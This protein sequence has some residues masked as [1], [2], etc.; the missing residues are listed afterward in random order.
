MKKVQWRDGNHMIFESGHRAFDRQTNIITTGNVIADTQYSSYI[1][2]FTETECNGFTN[3]PGH[4]QD[5]DLDGFPSLPRWIR[6]K[7]EGITYD[8]AAILY[9]FRHYNGQDKQVDGYVL[10]STE[11]AG[12]KLLAKWATGPTYKSVLALDEAIKYIT[13]KE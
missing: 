12:C 8:H 13:N 10:T 1:R 6:K 7:I 3:E 5:W 4:L 2:P 11:D 9:E